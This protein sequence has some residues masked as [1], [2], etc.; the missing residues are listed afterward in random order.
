M[1]HLKIIDLSGLI[2][3]L[4]YIPGEI[5]LN[6]YC[7]TWPDHNSFETC[8]RKKCLR[9][10]RSEV[11]MNQSEDVQICTLCINLYRHNSFIFSC[12]AKLAFVLV[13]DFVTY[14]TIIKEL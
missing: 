3:V 14:F 8:D 10:A 9:S 5:H 6:T 11:R 1:N 7:V 4:V 13:R 12:C 2:Q